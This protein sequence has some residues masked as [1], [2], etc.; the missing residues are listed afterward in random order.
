MKHWGEFPLALASQRH[1]SK[2]WPAK[3][4]VEE[5]DREIKA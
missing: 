5:T 4:K 1:S 2:K 3:L